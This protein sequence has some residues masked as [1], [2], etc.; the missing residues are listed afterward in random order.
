V[1]TV[2]DTA[3]VPGGALAAGTIAYVTQANAYRG[4]ASSALDRAA[5]A[6]KE[7][8]AVERRVAGGRVAG[9]VAKLS[10]RADL[11]VIGSRAYGPVLRVLAG[12]PG[13]S[14]TPPRSRCWSYRAAPATSW[15]RRSSRWRPPPGA[16]MTLGEDDHPP[17][18]SKPAAQGSA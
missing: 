4:C 3:G 18:D 10:E 14:C 17:L 2:A 5:S 16:G 11:L 9:A 1:I 12:T 13:R 6:A 7:D 8:I 15:T